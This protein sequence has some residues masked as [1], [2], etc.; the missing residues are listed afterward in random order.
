MKDETRRDERDEAGA[1]LKNARRAANAGNRS[2]AERWSKIAE[3]LSASAQKLA[4]P[5]PEEFDEEALCAEFR[6]RVARF[7]EADRPQREWE[8]A[9][10]IR[11]AVA[12]FA[13][14]HGLPEPPDLEPL[15]DNTAELEAIGAGWDVNGYPDERD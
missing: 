5:E 6:A 11:D 15:P 10:L 8:Q 2:E 7:V 14:A 12:E 13:R 9:K 3:R 1:A 4:P